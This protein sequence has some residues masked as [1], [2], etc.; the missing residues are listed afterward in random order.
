MEIIIII[1]VKVVPLLNEALV[2]E[3]VKYTNGLLEL[4]SFELEKYNFLI[5]TPTNAHT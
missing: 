4:Y 5:S 3:N 2:L 1:E